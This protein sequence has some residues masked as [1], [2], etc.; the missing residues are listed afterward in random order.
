MDISQAISSFLNGMMSFLAQTAADPIAYS[1]VLF[2]YAIMAAVILP[3]P[4]E[5]GLLLSPD[6]PVIWLAV[7]LGLGKMV[8]SVLVFYLGLGIGDKIEKWSAKWPGFGLLVSKSEWLVGKLHYLGLYLILS[9][10]L[11]SDTV[12]LYIFSILN[13]DGVFSVQMFAFTNLCAGITRASVLFI[14]LSFFGVN[15][16]H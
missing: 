3:I 6:T 12:P 16:F 2:F 7:V 5:V 13:K 9:V 8:G 10:P 15:L 4:V 11:M 14:L 1:V